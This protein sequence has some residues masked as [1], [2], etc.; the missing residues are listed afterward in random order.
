MDHKSACFGVDVSKEKLALARYGEE[1]VTEI[2]NT[3][4]AIARWLAALP[5]GAAIAMEATG[6]H[7]EW[8]AATAHA[9]GFRVF[10]LNPQRVHHYARAVGLRGKTDPVDA[11]L[12]ARYTAHEE[13]TLHPWQPP[14]AGNRA[15]AELLT[16]RAALVNARQ[17][18]AQSLSGVAAL[19][20]ERQ[21]LNEALR[22]MIARLERLIHAT[23]AKEP[24]LAALHRRLKTIVGVG[25]IVA[26]QL[27]QA[28]TRLR[29]P[30]VDAFIAYTGLDPRPDDSGTRRGRRRLSK[31][32]PGALRKLLF[33]AGRSAAPAASLSRSTTS[34]SAAD[35]K[36]PRRP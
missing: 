12:I 24:A 25:D 20:K 33:M 2:A 28:L 3:V 16:R 5:A 17:T 21:A 31:R 4:E 7:H 10:V 22:R 18:L 30:S 26:A 14:S 35:S 15:L 34:C 36:R 27:V 8:L 9:Q 11:R 1:A 32:G 13:A 29:F 19:A 23:L 6:R